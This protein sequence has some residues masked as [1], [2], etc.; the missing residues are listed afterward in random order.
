[1]ALNVAKQIAALKKMTVG[2]LRARY[3]EVFGEATR[4][5]NKD[6]SFK[7]IIVDKDSSGRAHAADVARRL[8]RP[9]FR[10]RSG[11]DR[12]GRRL[13]EVGH[14]RCFEFL[15]PRREHIASR[16]PPSGAIEI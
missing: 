9:Q 16:I 13:R 11:A 5:G 8:L 12:M 10:F 4:A 6:F 1:M 7:R 14:G 3:E 15:G 2:Q